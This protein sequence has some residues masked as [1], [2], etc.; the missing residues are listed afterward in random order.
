M[1]CGIH[2][3]IDH[4]LLSST[5][6]GSGPDR[7]LLVL[8]ERAL[9]ESASGLKPPLEAPRV[10]VRRPTT[11]IGRDDE[12]GDVAGGLGVEKADSPLTGGAGLVR[13]VPGRGRSTAVASELLID[14]AEMCLTGE[15]AE[16]ANGTGTEAADG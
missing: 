9:D 3:P 10:C 12:E 16:A 8:S 7:T 11:A 5:L 2:V 14:G 6:G 15:L 4:V 13:G 1:S